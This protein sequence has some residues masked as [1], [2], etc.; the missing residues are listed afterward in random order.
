M[1]SYLTFLSVTVVLIAIVPTLLIGAFRIAELKG[2]MQRR[3]GPNA[4][5]CKVSLQSNV[6]F[7]AGP[8]LMICSK[9]FNE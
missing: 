8:Y 9:E 4:T 5:P 2:S 1:R 7:I 3:L 6:S